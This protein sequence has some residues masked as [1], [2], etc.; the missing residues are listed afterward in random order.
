MLLFYVSSFHFQSRHSGFSV[1]RLFMVVSMSTHMLKN[2][3]IVASCIRKHL[4]LGNLVADY[5]LIRLLT[6]N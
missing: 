2:T 1:V 5:T 4:S 6:L 3:Q